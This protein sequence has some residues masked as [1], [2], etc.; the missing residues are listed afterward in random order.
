MKVGDLVLR[1]YKE[2]LPNGVLKS[3]MGIIIEVIN[4]DR[5]VPSIC[6][7]FW[8]SGDIAKEWADDIEVLNEGR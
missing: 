8:G 4:S 6:K 5:T 7:V 2:E 3:D 1:C